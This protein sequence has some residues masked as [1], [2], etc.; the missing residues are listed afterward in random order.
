[1]NEPTIRQVLYPIVCA[2]PRAQRIGELASRAQVAHSA[3]ERSVAALR[4]MCVIVLYGTGVYGPGPPGT[5]E[6]PYD[7][8]LPLRGLEEAW[9]R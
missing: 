6:R 4:Q 8:E 2:A 1:M 9:I 5:G 7:G 3:F